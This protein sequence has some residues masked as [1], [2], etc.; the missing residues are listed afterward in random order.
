MKSPVI[1]LCLFTLSACE[2]QRQ[3]VVHM[4]AASVPGTTLSPEGMESVRYA[5]NLKAYPLGRY[6]DPNDPDVMHEA[7]TIYRLETTA[8]WNLHP[9]DS[10]VSSIPAVHNQ[11]SASAPVLLRDELAV[12]LN[13]QRE[14]TK[15]II[16]S[17]QTIT[18]KLNDLASAVQKTRQIAENTAQRQSEMDSTIQNLKSLEEELRKLRQLEESNSTQPTIPNE[19][20]SEW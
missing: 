14:A 16:Q 4:T 19:T 13:R 8:K 2:T 18:Q 11:D 7:H 20:P 6:I 12:E 5:E 9:Q 3:S 15:I 17:G 1:L 10:P